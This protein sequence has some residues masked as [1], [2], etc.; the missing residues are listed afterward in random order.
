MLTFMS[1]DFITPSN[2]Y[3][4]VYAALLGSFSLLAASWADAQLPAGVTVA[5]TASAADE[6][7][8]PAAK[9]VTARPARPLYRR[10]FTRRRWPPLPLSLPQPDLEPDLEPEIPTLSQVSKQKAALFGLLVSSCVVL[11]ACSAYMTPYWVAQV[12]VIGEAAYGL[13]VSGLTIIVVIVLLSP[14]DDKLPETARLVIAIT[15]A[16]LWT[17]V[18]GAIT[19]S[20]PFHN[21]GNGFFAAWVGLYCA[22]LYARDQKYPDPP[23]WMAPKKKPKRKTVKKSVASPKKSVAA[24][25]TSTVEVALD[26]AAAALPPPDDEEGGGAGGEKKVTIADGEEGKPSADAADP[27]KN[28]EE[29][30]GEEEEGEE[31][32]GEEGKGNCIIA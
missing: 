6:A 7:G 18:V 15:L 13:A 22:F 14:F 23:A 16:V 26:G 1:P 17:A 29:G 11:I 20:Q 32:E 30:E 2:A 25:K 27:E 24:P 28:A 5:R 9:T 31:E 3:F 19:F 8:A 21:M 10:T 12:G 4:A